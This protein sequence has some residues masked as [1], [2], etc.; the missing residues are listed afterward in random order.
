MPGNGSALRLR[1]AAVAGIDFTSSRTTLGIDAALIHLHD[2]ALLIEQEGGRNA[3]IPAPVEE[4]AVDD[5]VD[6]R[7]FFGRKE[8]GKGNALPRPRTI[9]PCLR[10]GGIVD[11]DRQDF[12]LARCER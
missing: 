11:I 1:S 8:D 5:V 10:V 3:E 2:H 4:I 6:A 7:Y 12:H 9:A